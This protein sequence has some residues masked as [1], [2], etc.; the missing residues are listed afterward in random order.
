MTFATKGKIQSTDLEKH[1][2]LRLLNTFA[3]NGYMGPEFEAM[4][5][6]G[7][8]VCEDYLDAAHMWGETSLSV[9]KVVFFLIKRLIIN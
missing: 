4:T 5:E 7:A 9:K 8:R 1:F 6:V 2:L 3:K